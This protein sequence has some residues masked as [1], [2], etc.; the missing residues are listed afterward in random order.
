MDKKIVLLKKFL[1]CGKI[2]TDTRN[3]EEGSMFF[4]LKGENFD[5]NVFAEEALKKGAKYVVVDNAEYKTSDKCILVK[6]SLISLQDLANAYRKTFDITVLGITGSNGKTTTKE[7]I[8]AVL[9]KKFKI[10]YTKGNLN[11]HIGVPLTLLSMPKDTEIAVV[12]MGANHIG[13]IAQLCEIAEPNYGIITNIG[14]AHIEGF[15]SLEGIIEAKTE[16]Y[17]FI[18]QNAGILFVNS[19]DE[20]LES[21]SV[22]L[23]RI[24]YQKSET[25]KPLNSIPFFSLLWQNEEINTNLIGEYNFYNI[26]AACEIGAYFGVA[27]EDIKDAIENYQPK[28]QRSQFIET[29]NNKIVMDAYNA[30]PTS[31]QAALDA[32]SKMKFE[33]KYLILGDMLELGNI[34][35]DE[36]QKIYNT[37]QNYGF[38]NAVFVGEEFFKINMDAKY[39]KFKEIDKAIEYFKSNKLKSKSILIKASRGIK[40]EK[41]LEYLG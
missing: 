11:N 9:S 26:L 15:G 40:L 4:C 2:C 8:A 32:F 23:K 5:A 30:N 36:H 24:N 31:M 22:G 20:L 25:T 33:N 12:E 16:L 7:L 29:A 3:I 34:S 21:Q 37:V 39:L 41:V 1:E 35:H 10:H 17:R 38:E 19:D 14:K 18:N 13:E 6:D 28:N 27:K